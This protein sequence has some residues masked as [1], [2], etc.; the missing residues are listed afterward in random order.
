MS[1][2]GPAAAGPRP[3]GDVL[4]G[5]GIMA[6]LDPG[7]LVAGAVVL[8]KVVT[9]DGTPRLSS[10]HSEGMGWIERAGMVHTADAVE[11]SRAVAGLIDGA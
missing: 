10:L 6:S 5:L 4:D 7:D 1:G 9:A 2:D 8:L 3:I 11:T